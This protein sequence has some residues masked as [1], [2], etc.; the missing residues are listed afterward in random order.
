[1]PRMGFWPT[2]SLLCLSRVP[3]FSQCLKPLAGVVPSSLFFLPYGPTMDVNPTMPAFTTCLRF[4][5]PH[6]FLGPQ[7]G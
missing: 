2:S 5:L 6:C 1:M 7:P 4:T 3:H